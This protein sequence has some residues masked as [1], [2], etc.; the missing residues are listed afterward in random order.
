MKVLLWRTRS[1]ERLTRDTALA[2]ES[3][4]RG[5][6]PMRFHWL[7]VALKFVLI[8]LAVKVLLVILLGPFL[9]HHWLSLRRTPA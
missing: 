5:G 7:A 8:T 9:A 3:A 1:R 2:V 4:T 6:V